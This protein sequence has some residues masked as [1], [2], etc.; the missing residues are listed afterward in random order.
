MNIEELYERVASLPDRV[1]NRELEEYLLALY[2]NVLKHKEKEF[3]CELALALF[4]QSF[5]SEPAEFQEAW[6]Q[7]EHAPDERR[8]S[9]KF[10][11]PAVAT[12]FDNTDAS[13]LSPFDFTIAVLQFQIAELHNMRGKQL[14]D[15]YRYFGLR[16]ET[17]NYWFNFDPS[18]NL[19]CGVRCMEDNDES[20]D[21]ASWSLI[22]EILEKGR[23][24]E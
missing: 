21:A 16:S 15:E 24:Y 4:E 17:G 5:T 19:E 23:I 14:N 8:I 2:G 22:G 3:S 1:E 9:K 18:T 13:V 6:L 20:L 12:L 11:H 7:C 10:A